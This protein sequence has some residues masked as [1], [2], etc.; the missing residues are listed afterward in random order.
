MHALA[1]YLA[2]HRFKDLFIEIL[3]WDRANGTLE[4]V[5]DGRAFQLSLVAQKRGLQVLHGSTDNLTLI[6]RGRLRRLQQ[7]VSASIHEHVLICSSESPRKQ[8]WQWAVRLSDGRRFRHREHPFFS[9]SPPPR[10]LSRLERLRF[11]LEEEEQVTLIDALG[12]TREAFDAPAEQNL[13]VHRPWY[14]ERS[15]ELARALEAGDEAALQEFVEFHRPLVTW[16]VRPLAHL[17][18]GSLEDAEQTGMLGLIYAARNYQRNRG[19]QFSTYAVRCI[20]GFCKREAPLWLAPVRM[21]NDV[22]WRCFKLQRSLERIAAKGGPHAVAAFLE[23]LTT[24]N[25]VLAREWAQFQRA[26]GVQSLSPRSGSCAREARKLPAPDP[27]GVDLLA[28][29]ERNVLVRATVARLK[30]RD[31]AFVRMKYGFDG[32]K[33]TLEQ[34]GRQYGVTRERVRQRLARVATKL[35]FSLSTLVERADSDNGNGD[36]NGKGTPP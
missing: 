11:T 1:P 3:G 16:A 2:E 5:A 32:D 24:R 6:N 23:R 12:R 9:V 17:F 36:D 13:F 28:E 25:P 26:V 30:P 4:V 35:K 15:D 19:F 33:Q 31:A 8:V 14:A 7:K 21:P 29:K 20:Q 27:T 22:M 18:K 34:I 10:L